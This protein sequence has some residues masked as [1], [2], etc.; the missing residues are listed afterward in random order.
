MTT[1]EKTPTNSIEISIVSELKGQERNEV[2]NLF[3]N[4]PDHQR[5]LKTIQRQEI[6]PKELSLLLDSTEVR[7][8]LVKENA[9]VVGFFLVC[10]LETA[11]SMNISSTNWY[12]S[13]FE[14]PRTSFWKRLGP[15]IQEAQSANPQN[16]R[17]Y[18]QLELAPHIPQEQIQDIS[19]NLQQRE[20]LPLYMVGNGW[21]KTTSLEKRETIVSKAHQ[22]LS[23]E[24]SGRLLLY[25]TPASYPTESPYAR[26]ILSQEDITHT[27]TFENT[28]PGIRIGAQDYLITGTF[29]KL[30]VPEI[31]YT[32]AEKGYIPDAVN[33][34]LATIG[35]IIPRNKKGNDLKE[36][37]YD[38]KVKETPA[39]LSVISNR[40]EK[41]KIGDELWAAYEQT[42]HR[43]IDPHSEQRTDLLM[44][45][46]IQDQSAVRE[47][48]DTVLLNDSTS[49]IL[50]RDQAGNIGSF[51]IYFNNPVKIHE[52][53]VD[54]SGG[55]HSLNIP[56]ASALQPICYT[57]TIGA[58]PNHEGFVSKVEEIA[59][60]SMA[61]NGIHN[62]GDM[63][64]TTPSQPSQ[65]LI[66]QILK[67]VKK[68]NAQI[69]ELNFRIPKTGIVLKLPIPKLRVTLQRHQ[70]WL[71]QL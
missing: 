70:W 61:L 64:M 26:N 49:V 68:T 18:G 42:F 29:G 59:S 13:S 20:E 51:W 56:F 2:E 6:M 63:S 11:K 36:G 46:S 31:F 41:E 28:F 62:G 69:D 9:Q 33:N 15:A 32:L 45:Q 17:L 5:G 12:Q 14:P 3:L 19:T 66:H 55:V 1:I 10:E 21:L 24:Y 25:E 54:T 71:T 48:F 52:E 58:T 34:L 22:A 44:V 38:I 39:T 50:V 57:Y 16:P 30:K 60:R 4:S 43:Y 47:E 23:Q 35:F 27:A 8:V 40:A 65:I 7:K 53:T 67:T 37:T